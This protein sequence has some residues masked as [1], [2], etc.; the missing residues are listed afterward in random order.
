[1][2]RQAPDAAIALGPRP[3]GTTLTQWLYEELRSAILSGRLR[4]G[5]RL[6]ASRDM[7]SVYG[8][9]RRV[10][11]NVF[12]QLQAEGYLISRVGAGTV[13]GEH[14]PEDYA[15]HSAAPPGPP[16]QVDRT[17]AIYRRPVRPFR[18]IEPALA[19]FPVSVW[20]KTAAR[21]LRQ[22]S[23]RSLAGGELAGAP[24]LREEI[25]H[26]L[27]NSRSVA[28]SADQIVIVSGTQQ[29]LDLLARL[30]LEPGDPVWME[31]PG[32]AGAVEVFRNAKAKIIPV[33]VDEH[34]LD[35]V[36]GRRLCA[37]PK[38]VYLTPAHQFGIGTTLS[39]ERRF[40]LLQWSAAS[41][42][43]LWEDDYD[44]EFRFSGRPVPAMKSLDGGDSVFLLGTFNKILF[45]SLRLGYIVAPHAWVDRL[46]ALRF[47]IDRYPPAIP[48]AILGRFMAEGH[49]A[50]HLRRMRELYAQ[51]CGAMQYD[52][53]R[54]LKG[55]LRL[56]EIQAGLCTPAYLTNGMTSREASARAS[57]A[58]LEAWPLDAACLRR[59]DLH[60]LILGFAAFN[61]QEIRNGVL[62][63]AKAL[64]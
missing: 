57:E 64:T 15:A 40:D 16:F 43:I 60:G 30:L 24:I 44:S 25:A 3:P 51:R 1:M 63:L 11:V 9:S 61:E 50:R 55:A 14:V 18:P 28:C 20:S 33:R 42:A 59:R 41:G 12:E 27:G 58:G 17:L 48:Q 23:I 13:V 34:G 47:Q 21:S 32:Y 29:A 36:R 7:A 54:Y 10:V 37:H 46:L 19:E 52:V 35:P 31:D 62:G 45:P 38:V 5:A 6:P 53:A 8:I 39:L 2:P 26:F 49:F 4:R 22:I 56:P